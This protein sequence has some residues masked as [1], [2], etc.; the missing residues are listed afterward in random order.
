MAIRPPLE[1]DGSDGMRYELSASNTEAGLSTHPSVL[2]PGG[3][4]GRLAAGGSHVETSDEGGSAGL[5]A[6]QDGSQAGPGRQPEEAGDETG[7]SHP[8]GIR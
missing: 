7:Y 4:S 1:M 6:S 2:I 5:L 3:R 8:F